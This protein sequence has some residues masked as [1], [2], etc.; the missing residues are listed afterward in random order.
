MPVYQLLGGKCR[1]GAA[2]YRHADGNDHHAVED[3]FRAFLEQ[4]YRYI[5][6]QLGGY[7]G[8]APVQRRPEQSTLGAYYDPEAYARSVPKLFEH[9]RNTF[10]DEVELLHDVHER[11]EPVRAIRLAKELERFR[12]FF[13]EDALPPEQVDWLKMLRSQCATPIAIG[14]LFTNP[15]EWVPLISQ[16]LIDFARVRLGAIGGITPAIK[17][18]HLCETFGVRTAWHGPPDVSPIGH[19]ANLHLDVAMRSFGIQEFAGYQDI[20]REIFPG[21]AEPRAGYLY[22]NDAPGLGI[23]FN[24]QLAAKYPVSDGWPDWTCARRP[25]GSINYP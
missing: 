13:L 14:E 17:L 18:A 16:R 9:I 2:V 25:D 24:E 21:L 1:D 19:M 8:C 6:C 15:A 5:R 11:L 20:E 12:L 10:G 7:G 22:P 23:G 4:G 3:E